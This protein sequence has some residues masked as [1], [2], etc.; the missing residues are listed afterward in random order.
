MAKLPIRNK[1][2]DNPYI[3]GYDEDKK[4]YTVEFVDNKKVTHK[5]AISVEVYNAFD[6][7]ELEDVSQIHKYQRHIEHS[8]V[9]EETLNNR[10]IDKPLG[11]DEIV[12]NK[13]IYD[14]LKKAIN[15]LSEVQK[16]RIKLYYFENKTLKEIATLEQCSIMS[17]KESIDSGIVKLKKILKN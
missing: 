9:Y 17:V 1:S 3:L 15:T 6:S 14:E 5:I 16:R 10:A 8:E 7:F 11:V 4:T 13:M 12:E 2:K